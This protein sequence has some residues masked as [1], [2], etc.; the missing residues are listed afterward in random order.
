MYSERRGIQGEAL[1]I[2][3]DPSLFKRVYNHTIGSV[4]LCPASV[5]CA[6]MAKLSYSE[7]LK[8]IIC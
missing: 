4:P 3:G 6:I 2:V 8:D 1:V 5:P 7:T